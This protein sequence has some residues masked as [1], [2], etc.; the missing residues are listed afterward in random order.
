MAS[1]NNNMC[2]EGFTHV[3]IVACKYLKF[4]MNDSYAPSIG[5]EI[6][7]HDILS[8]T[9]VASTVPSMA[10]SV[11]RICLGPS[12]LTSYL[13]RTVENWDRATIPFHP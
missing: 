4:H 3:I 11:L 9:Y 7:V 2:R 10:V 12:R 13:G 6:D 8:N 5:V 1:N